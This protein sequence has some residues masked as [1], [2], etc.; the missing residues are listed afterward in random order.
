MKA[1]KVL[2]LALLFAALA[3]P[4]WAICSSTCDGSANCAF[5]MFFAE[6]CHDYGPIC[7][8]EYCGVVVIEDNT[9]MMVPCSEAAPP[10]DPVMDAPPPQ[11]V[12]E[13]LPRRT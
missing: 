1:R 11:L 4:S 8:T 3:N 12:V 10:A 5:R 2:L 6:I 9:A 7:F 13:V